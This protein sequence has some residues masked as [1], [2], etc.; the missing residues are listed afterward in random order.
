ML[1]KELLL[2]ILLLHKGERF[3]FHFLY[4]L[5]VVLIRTSRMSPVIGGMHH[6]AT[7]MS[8]SLVNSC[9]MCSTSL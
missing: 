1:T 7:V 8:A 6:S 3:S 5:V 2:G 9:K 4:Y